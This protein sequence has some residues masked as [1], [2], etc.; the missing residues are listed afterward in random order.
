MKI[1][2]AETVNL[3]RVTLTVLRA[4]EAAYIQVKT[5][6]LSEQ[7]KHVINIIH[8]TM[9]SGGLG[10]RTTLT[11]LWEADDEDP[12]YQKYINIEKYNKECE[13]IKR[14]YREKCS[15]AK[16]NM[17]ERE[18]QLNKEIESIEEQ[19]QRLVNAQDGEA[20][21]VIA[22]E[23]ENKS[24]P[25]IVISIVLIITAI[26]ID[27]IIYRIGAVIAMIA[28][29]YV[30][31]PKLRADIKSFKERKESLQKQADA[32]EHGEDTEHVEEIERI[33]RE[34]NN[35]QKDLENQLARYKQ[36]MERELADAKAAIADI[37]N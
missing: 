14:H 11:F 34:I 7:G 1:S 6:Q 17:K 2:G 33:K 22:E 29:W 4:E 8:G 27:S 18:K 35:L 21:K 15:A 19:V 25:S 37:E 9:Q 23:I 30:Y 12:I 26:C 20:G 24:F 28:V 13:Q 10:Y 36:E 32:L 31:Y 16:S 3:D 5:R